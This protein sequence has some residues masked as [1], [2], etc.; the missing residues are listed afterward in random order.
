MLVDETGHVVTD[1]GEAL[2]VDED[3]PSDPV[4]RA[5]QSLK[6]ELQAQRET[7]QKAVQQDLAEIKQALAALV[8]S[9]AG[10]PGVGGGGVGGGGM[11]SGGMEGGGGMGGGGM[12]G[13]GMGGGGSGLGGGGMSGGTGMLMPNGGGGVG[14]GTIG[15]SASGSSPP[16]GNTV[17]HRRRKKRLTPAAS[18]QS[19]Q[20]GGLSAPP[21]L[22]SAS[23]TAQALTSS[24]SSG[25]ELSA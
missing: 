17:Q 13:G 7:D 18:G 2:N 5:L 20:G 15:A 16:V 14:I 10:Q 19:G 25:H 12:G 8:A 6:Q 21:T 11:G 23:L 3:E 24:C 22:T 4:L 9:K 1:T